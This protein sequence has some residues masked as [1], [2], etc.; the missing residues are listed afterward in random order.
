[1]VKF[2]LYELK[3]AGQPQPLPKKENKRKLFIVTFFY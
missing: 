3:V 1:M 2:L